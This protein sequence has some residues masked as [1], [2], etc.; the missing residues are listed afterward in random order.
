VIVKVADHKYTSPFDLVRSAVEQRHH[1][2]REAK[3]GKGSAYD[4]YWCMFDVDEH[5]LI[6]E[7]LELAASN[8]IGIALSSPCLELW[9]VIHFERRT[10]YIERDEATRISQGLLGCRKALTTDALDLLAPRYEDAKAHAELLAK[11]HL[12]DG[13]A[14]PWNPYSDVWKLVDE[15]RESAAAT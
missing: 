5:L 6:P 9:F 7:A 13:T 11:K 15:I 2:L 3:R 1:D 8:D 4:Q 14:L 12:G 10:A